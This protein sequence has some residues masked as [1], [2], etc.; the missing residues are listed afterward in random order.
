MT[1]EDTQP[2][3]EAEHAAILAFAIELAERASEMIIA[4][5]DARWTQPAGVDAKA[6]SVDVRLSLSPTRLVQVSLATSL[7]ESMGDWKR[8][9]SDG[10]S[11]K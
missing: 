6:N 4:G 2:R 7:T 8:R 1:S 5:S 11:H 3:I 9:Y 10:S